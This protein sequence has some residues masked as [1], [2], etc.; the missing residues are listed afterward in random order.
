MIHFH[1]Q[2]AR[3]MPSRR[4]ASLLVVAT[5]LLL[6]PAV[7]ARDLPPLARLQAM[8]L[9]TT[10]HGRV[11][12]YFAPADRARAEEMAALTE[13]AAAFFERTRGLRF[14]LGVAALAPEDWFSD[15]PGI[16]YA[17]PWPSMP[18]RLIFVPS[19]LEEGLLVQGPTELDDRRRVDFVLLHEY[20]HI[21]ARE[22]FRPTDEADYLKVKWFEELLATYF[23]HA[24]LQASDPAWARAARAAWLDEVG[25]HAPAVLS[26]DWSFMNDLPGDELA[27]TYAWYQFVLNLRAAEIHDDHGLEFLR[28]LKGRLPWQEADDWTT[29][30]LLPRLEAIAPG[31]ESWEA[32]LATVHGR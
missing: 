4:L 26:L 25:G 6:S 12:A 22:Y 11:T 2:N 8:G 5:S 10:E 23:A 7:Q 9:E 21:A 15:I 1:V 14:D 31:F 19:S 20:G 29:A 13:R 27:R 18:E 3:G 24:F 17:I 30:G 32:S 28:A 16:P